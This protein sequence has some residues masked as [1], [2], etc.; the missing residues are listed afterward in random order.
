MT[1]IGER[2]DERN[3]C[4][5]NPCINGVC[6]STS[7]GYHCA[8][9]PGLHG[10]RCDMDVNECH[11]NPCH[12]GKCVNEFG[13]YRC[14]CPRGFSGRHCE[15]FSLSNDPCAASPCQNGA[16]CYTYRDKYYSCECRAGFTGRHCEVNIDDCSEN[17]CM[18]G[19]RFC[20]QDVDECELGLH[21]C[22]NGGTC[23]NKKEGYH[24][25]CVNGWEGEHC[26]INKDDCVD[27]LCEAGSTCVDHVAKY[28]CE[29][30]PGR[31]GLFCHM[32]DPCL[33]NPCRTGS[34]CEPDTSS[35]KYTC[36]C[37]KGYTGEDCSEDINECEQVNKKQ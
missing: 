5:G 4:E 19:G 11:S 24:C 30:P 21:D 16:K 12:R 20:E 36:E 1:L 27:A 13:S 2:C 37:P 7:K 25:V 28:T 8:C 29:C 14:E 23:F 10:E 9:P 3:Y 17:A 6:T 35:G 31:I 22:K 33:A 34:V 32:E 18:N 26:E 15:T